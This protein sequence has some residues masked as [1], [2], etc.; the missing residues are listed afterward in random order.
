M[1]LSLFVNYQEFGLSGV[2]FKER[3]S[4]EPCEWLFIYYFI[5]VVVVVFSC[6]NSILMFGMCSTRGTCWS[7]CTVDG[8]QIYN[9]LYSAVYVS[10]LMNSES[11]VYV[12]FAV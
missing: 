1:L 11:S 2:L 7:S 4:V 9:R 12:L 10:F 8:P 5:V 3:D 6:L